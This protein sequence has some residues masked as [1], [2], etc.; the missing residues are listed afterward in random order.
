MDNIVML[1]ILDNDAGFED[2]LLDTFIVKN[3]TKEA[4]EGLRVV[5]AEHYDLDDWQYSMVYDYIEKH[6]D[7]IDYNVVSV[8]Y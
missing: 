3:P 1:K 5:L 4:L 6:F 7:V 8:E 2:R